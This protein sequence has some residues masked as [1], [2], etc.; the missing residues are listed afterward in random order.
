M[1]K[2]KGVGT[3]L[4]TPFKNGQVDYDSLK[5]IINNLVS[6]AIKYTPP[7]KSIYFSAELLKEELIEY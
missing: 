2:Y 7:Q 1:S 4:V 3:A 6:N 5:K